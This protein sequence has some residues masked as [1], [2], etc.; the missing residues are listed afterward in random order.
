MSSRSGRLAL[1]FSCIGHT[2]MHV[3][4][5]LYLTVVLVLET[6]WQLSYDHLLRLWTL[7][8]LL[9]GVGAPIAGWLGDRWS[10]SRMM[11]VFHIITG[12]G[13]VLAGLAGDETGLMLG[14]ALLGIGASI[15]HPVGLAWIVKNAENRGNALAWNGIWGGVGIAGAGIVAGGLSDFV[16]W[17]AAMIVPGLISIATGLLLA[18]LIARGVMVDRTVDA[19]PMLRPSR[20]D[21]I[22][23]FALLSVTM[24]C[25]GLVYNSFMTI[26][27]KWFGD[28]I[29]DLAGSGTMA[30]GGM[31]SLVFLIGA[32]PQLIG[33]WLIDRYP[34]KRIYVATLMLQV[35]MLALAVTAVGY[36]LFALAAFTIAVLSIQV[37]AENELL[38]R[39]TPA[40]HRG[41]AF[42]AKFVLSFGSGP[43]AVQFAAWSYDATGTFDTLLLALTALA[44][45]AVVAAVLL[46]DRGDAA[47]R[48]AAP[49]P[50][51]APG[52]AD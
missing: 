7:G 24:L 4:A 33:G 30:I 8:A 44:C 41:L 2:Q 47:P 17:R 42:G 39:F 13:A 25:A 49:A 26:L 16:S 52:T 6:D 14:L 23:V 48:P 46:P 5:G 3:L 35:P 10:E 50:V 51:P 20:G 12:L 45:V 1:V 40:R 38:A 9:I 43:A 28:R 21:T 32:M 31:V 11:V 34:P 36:P 19:K 27:P 22:R 29:P 15:Y 37:P 18:V